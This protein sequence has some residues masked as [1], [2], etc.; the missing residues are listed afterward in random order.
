MKTPKYNLKIKEEFKDKGC[1]VLDDFKEY[2]KLNFN[3][4]NADKYHNEFYLLFDMNGFTPYGKLET[5][6]TESSLLSTDLNTHKTFPK[7]DK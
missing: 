5:S 1:V 6:F 3:L 2:V 4:I 7:L